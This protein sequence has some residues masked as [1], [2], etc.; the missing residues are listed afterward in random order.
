MSFKDYEKEYNRSISDPNNFWKEKAKTI[1]WI[2][3]FT[4]VRESTFEKNVAIKWFSDGTLNVSYNCLDRHVENGIMSQNKKYS[5]NWWK[6]RLQ[7]HEFMKNIYFENNKDYKNID[8]SITK[9]L[10]NFLKFLNHK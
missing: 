3:K 10:V 9:I 7:A 1:T 2:K 8:F 4:K 6:K 5:F